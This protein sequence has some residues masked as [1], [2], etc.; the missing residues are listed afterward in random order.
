[1]VFS[2]RDQRTLLDKMVTLL[3]SLTPL[4][5]QPILLI[6]DAYYA[7]RKVILPLLDLGHQLITRARRNTVAYYPARRP[8]TPRRGRPRIY[9][10]KVR[11]RDLAQDLTQ[12]KTAPSPIDTDI[13]VRL[14]YRCVD[15][16]WRPV[17]RLVR[18]VLVRHPQRGVIFLM[19]TDTAL[20]PLE[21]VMLY[22]HRF[23]IEI[24]F[25]HAL[26]V[27]GSYAYHFWMKDMTPI[28]VRTGD[29]YLHRKTDSYR[30]QV[31]RK[32]RAYHLHVQLGCIAQGLLQ[33]LALHRGR[34]VWSQFRSWLRTMNPSQPPS[35][36]VT[37]HA[38]RD[39][40]PDF[41]DELACDAETRK[42]LRRFKRPNRRAR[43]P[44]AA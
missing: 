42:F 37:A 24:G 30:Q 31:R 39:R 1:L 27:L 4:S 8:R 2:N 29:Q 25:K 10:K 34:V 23:K 14:Q 41:L 26:H 12:F 40:L 33:H 19:A 32:L 43:L 21:I 5:R 9:G 13:N 18:F 3:H 28:R 36:L 20:D 6:A 11:L 44:W 22:A 15:L 17:G 38:L 35:E 16:L 7:S